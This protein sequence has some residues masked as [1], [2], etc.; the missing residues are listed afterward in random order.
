LRERAI[1]GAACLSGAA[2]GYWPPM[3]SGEP[4]MNGAGVALSW[5]A[6]VFAP[7][8]V[9]LF[10]LSLYFNN[11]QK[12]FPALVC[13][14][15]TFAFVMVWLALAARATANPD[16]PIRMFIP[17]LTVFIVLGTAFLAAM[18]WSIDRRIAAM[19]AGFAAFYIV[20]GW[21]GVRGFDARF[22]RPELRVVPGKKPPRPNGVAR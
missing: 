19:E 17:R 8:A 3:A 16:S 14:G 4:D 7:A 21:F 18:Q 5:R 22:R 2:C 6:I 13:L 20:A 12:Q 15:G 9:V 1:A 10:A 11:A